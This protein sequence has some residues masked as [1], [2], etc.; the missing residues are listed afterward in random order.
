MCPIDRVAAGV[1][2][3]LWIVLLTACAGCQGPV[4][5]TP[6]AV[7]ASAV[8]F[9]VYPGRL[10]QA[11]DFFYA[12]VSGDRE[13]VAKAEALL[14]ELGGAEARDPQ[15][16]AYLGGCR[17]LEAAHTPLPWDKAALAHQGL[18]LEDRA[19]ADAPDD[20]EVRSLRGI[21]SYQLPRF[22]GRWNLAV[23][24]L[25]G[26]A[27]VAEREAM[28]GRLDHRAAS[29]ALDYYGKLLEQKYEVD[30]AIAAWRAALRVDAEGQGGRDAAKHL[31]E[32]RASPQEADALRSGQAGG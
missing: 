12:A 14:E 9:D 32:H 15:V 6:Q 3:G 26:V 22:M 21:T 13:A 31:L 18:A 5:Q 11:K 4:R 17:L 30:G 8:S 29:A 27:R 28:E 10:A 25:G 16:V 24:D 2:S 23:S 19:V 7:V 1:L 20:L